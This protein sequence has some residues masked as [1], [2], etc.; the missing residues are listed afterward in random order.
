M[1]QIFQRQEEIREQL[2]DLIPKF[3]EKSATS[4]KKP[5]RRRTGSPAAVQR[6]NAETTWKE[7]RL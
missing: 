3:K 6:C 4:P 5:N 1:T 2:I 7:R